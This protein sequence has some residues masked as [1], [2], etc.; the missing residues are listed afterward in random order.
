MSD[1]PMTYP[2]KLRAI[3]D[4]FEH[5]ERTQGKRYALQVMRP[6][7]NGLSNEALQESQRLRE[8]TPW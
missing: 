4:Q 1:Q 7:L 8:E 2:E 5:Y 3:A 6:V